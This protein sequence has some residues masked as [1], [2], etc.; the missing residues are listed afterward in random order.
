MDIDGLSGIR[1]FERFKVDD[2]VLPLSYEND[3]V[4]L[5]M[6]G[7]ERQVFAR[8][9]A[10]GD[11]FEKLGE[12]INEFHNQKSKLGNIILMAPKTKQAN[13]PQNFTISS[14]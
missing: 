3:I 10:Q 6:E 1:L 8:I 2:K 12:K 11:S 14:A 7:T 9:Y 4:E 5:G 13:Q